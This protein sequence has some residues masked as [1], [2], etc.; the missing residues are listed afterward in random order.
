MMFNL[1]RSGVCR[2]A[3]EVPDFFDRKSITFVSVQRIAF[4]R[5]L[6]RSRTTR[7]SVPS[8]D[9]R[10][11]GVK[12]DV[13]QARG[14]LLSSEREVPDPVQLLS[15]PFTNGVGMDARETCAGAKEGLGGWRQAGS[16]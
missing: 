5:S 14:K 11:R 4:L 10:G 9:R 16:G 1:P 6:S 7:R 3:L 13:T 15:N 8:L 12:S 2:A